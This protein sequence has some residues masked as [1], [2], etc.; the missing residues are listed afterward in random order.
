MPNTDVYRLYDVGGKLLYV[1]ISYDAIFRAE[2]HSKGKKWWSDVAKI[3]IKRHSTRD[4]AID[5]EER[6]IRD[7]NPT[8]NVM[9]RKKGEPACSDRW[10]PR[11]QPNVQ[12]ADAP[13]R[14]LKLKEVQHLSAMGKSSIYRNIAAGIFPKP[15]ALGSGS[16][17]WREST[18]LQWM[19]NLES[20]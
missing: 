16:V 1:G 15:V 8:Y 5:E 7:E 6:A 4:A 17:R 13:D 10:E 11:S 19:A 12:H 9:C 2:Q 3:D 18:I 14:L 20:T